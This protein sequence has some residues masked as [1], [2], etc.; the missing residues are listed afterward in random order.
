MAFRAI[1]SPYSIILEV[2]YFHVSELIWNLA[3]VEPCLEE[4][5]ICT[6]MSVAL[7]PCHACKGSLMPLS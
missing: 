4:K 1:A 2:E 7:L 5:L 6:A 3:T